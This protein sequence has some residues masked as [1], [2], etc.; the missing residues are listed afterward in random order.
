[1]MFGWFRP[2]CPVTPIEKAW[3]ERRLTWLADTFGPH[4]ML[5]AR[6]ILPTAEF[7]RDA[8]SGSEAEARALFELVGTYMGVST[9]RVDLHF[10]SHAPRANE[11]SAIPDQPQE[12]EEVW[13]DETQL[14][15]PVAA[16]GHDGLRA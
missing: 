10:F 11:I 9:D 7:F 16:R 4:R 1:M 15:D 12:Q 14:G 3:I 8:Y 5:D 6:V 13:L 2:H